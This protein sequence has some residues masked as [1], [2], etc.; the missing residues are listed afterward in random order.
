MSD[1]VVWFQ[2]LKLSCLLMTK[3]RVNP[4]FFRLVVGSYPKK[5]VS[6][7]CGLGQGKELDLK[8]NGQRFSL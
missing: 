4:T 6:E 8:S 5:R 3:K 1:A 7:G 2:K